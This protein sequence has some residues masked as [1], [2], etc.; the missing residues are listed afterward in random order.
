MSIHL[1]LLLD[2]IT[3]LAVVVGPRP[4]LRLDPTYMADLSQVA[5]EPK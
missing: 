2:F 5:V 1:L 3:S 4:W